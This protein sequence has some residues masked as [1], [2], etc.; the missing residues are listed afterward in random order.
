M[1]F[2]DTTPTAPCIYAGKCVCVHAVGV[3]RRRRVRA[4]R[5]TVATSQSCDP[6]NQAIRPR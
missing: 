6:S 4:R 5:V 2:S 3:G 1:T